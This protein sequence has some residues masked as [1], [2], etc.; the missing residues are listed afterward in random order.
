MGRGCQGSSVLFEGT[1]LDI[2]KEGALRSLGN[3]RGNPCFLSYVGISSLRL[4]LNKVVLGSQLWTQRT[5]EP[6]KQSRTQIL[7]KNGE[8]GSLQDV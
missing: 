5:V 4:H 3:L 7:L 1:V 6:W 2:H 8:V